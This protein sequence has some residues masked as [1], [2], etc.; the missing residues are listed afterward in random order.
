MLLRANAALR[1]LASEPPNVNKARAALTEI[2]DGGQ[3]IG[4]IISNLRAMFRKGT[5]QKTTFDTNKQIR[6]VLAIVQSDLRKQGIESRIS[7]GKTSRLS[8]ATKFNCSK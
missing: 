4:E 7:L 2:V 3:R 5:E 1:L 6:S 8:P